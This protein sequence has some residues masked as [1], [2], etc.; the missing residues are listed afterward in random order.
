MVKRAK[1]TLAAAVDVCVWSVTAIF[2]VA[3]A[4]AACHAVVS[5]GMAAWHL[6][7]L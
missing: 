5:A 2:G 3:L 6:L 1:L 4:Y 7:G